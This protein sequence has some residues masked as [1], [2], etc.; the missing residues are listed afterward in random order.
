MKQGSGP[1]RGRSPVEWGDFPSVRPSVDKENSNPTNW[2]T[3]VKQGKGTA[4]H[5]VPLGGV[6]SI[7]FVTWLL[8]NTACQYRLPYTNLLSHPLSDFSAIACKLN[9]HYFVISP[10]IYWST[11]RSVI[12]LK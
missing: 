2:K 7:K 11:R 10:Q 6:L 5:L 4:D 12:V 9:V 1:G 3:I 8:Y